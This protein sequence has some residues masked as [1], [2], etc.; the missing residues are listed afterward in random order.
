MIEGC[1][2]DL[3][4]LGGLCN[5][6]RAVAS[7]VHLAHVSNGSVTIHWQ[8]N[9]ECNAYFDE[10]FEAIE[11]P[12]VQVLRLHSWK[13]PLLPA[14]KKNL[15][16]PVFL[17]KY[18]Y[19]AQFFVSHDRVDDSLL[20]TL[21]GKR[22]YICSGHSL[23]AH[24]PLSELFKPLPSL[25]QRIQSIQAVFK[26]NVVGVHIRRGDHKRCIDHCSEQDFMRSMDDVLLLN[27]NT[28]FYVATDSEMLKS[29]LLERY[30]QSVVYQSAE[31]TRTSL[32]GI[33]DAVVDLW[34]LA[35]TSRIIGSP[36][37]SYSDLAAELGRLELQYPQSYVV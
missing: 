30:G 6:L 25:M 8:S 1:H 19:D 24:Y 9:A 36:F 13:L 34:C 23:S 27:P 3:V 10:L 32:Q 22:F 4:P 37:S 11:L 17:R 35:S 7:A 26:P 31:L 15:Q 21:C 5:R 33:R 2:I 18:R 16:L 28:Q 20:D 29:K 12:F 14:R